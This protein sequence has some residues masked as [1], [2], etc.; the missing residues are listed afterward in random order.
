MELRQAS[1]TDARR[2]RLPIHGGTEVVPLLRGGPARRRT[3]SSTSAASCRAGSTGT[4]IGAGATLAELECDPQVPAAL[5]EACRLA[6]SPQ[7]R[8]MGSLGGNLLQATRCW[9]WRLEL[10]VPPARRRRVLRARGRAPRARDLRERLLR[11]GAPVRRRRRAARARRDA[12]HRP[13]RA[14]ARRA[15]PRADRG[16]PA[17]DDAR[18]GRADP[19]GRASPR[20]T[21]GLPEG[22]GAQAL[23]VP[24]RRRRGGPDARC[25]EGRARRRRPD[26]VAARGAA[27]RRDAA[28]AERVQGRDREGARPAGGQR[29]VRAEW[30]VDLA[31][32]SAWGCRSRSSSRW[33]PARRGLEGLAGHD[34]RHDDG[35]QRLHDGRPAE[36]GCPQGRE[37]DRGPRP[38][39]D[40]HGHDADELRQVHDPARRQD[41]AG[42]RPRRS[43]SLVRKGFFDGTSSTGSCPGFMIQGGDPTA[44]GTGG[45]GYSTVDKP[46]ADDA[47]H[48][49]HRRDGEDAGR[50]GRHG[51]SQFFVVTGAG[52]RAAARLRVARRGRRRARRRRRIGELGDAEHR[53][54]D[55]DGRDRAGDRR[56]VTLTVAAVVL[57][58]GAATRYGG[59]EAAG[60]APGR[61][62]RARRDAP[63]D[64]VVVVAG[65]ATRSSGLPRALAWSHCDRL[66]RR[67]RRVAAL[68]PRRARRRRRRT[69]WSCSPTGPSSTRARSSGCSSTAATAPV[70]AASYDGDARATRSCSRALSGTTMPDEGGARARAAARRLLRP[71]AAGRR[72]FPTLRQPTA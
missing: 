37:A 16:R 50:A 6:A 47:L 68:R 69:R 51:G 9:Y 59:A 48:A 35:C 36:A 66:G 43:L 40:L 34:D 3:R 26:P 18:A 55:R 49:R 58:A 60:A 19:R 2:R 33:P 23:G 42:R 54:A 30:N 65:R 13:A 1:S 63:V 10:A 62:R 61:A 44:T 7:L 72:R 22:D 17:H 11:L 5:R 57:A 67:A 14:A 39:E 32:R 8:N 24:A 21:L 64:E 70:V 12:A 15:L 52:R 56:L 29:S 41:V 45:P 4:R 28:A 25:D 53:A 38:V 20:P 31:W 27:R 46:P 71:R